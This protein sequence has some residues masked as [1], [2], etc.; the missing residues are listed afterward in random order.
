MREDRLVNRMKLLNS[1]TVH[2]PD[3]QDLEHAVRQQRAGKRKKSA[4]KIS[5]KGHAYIH[6]SFHL[7]SFHRLCSLQGGRMEQREA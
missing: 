6:I 4:T 1:L 3:D 2:Q 7:D 5:I